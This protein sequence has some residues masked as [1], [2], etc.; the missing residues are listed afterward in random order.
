H[1]TVFVAPDVEHHSSIAE[2]IRVA[3]IL[4][5]VMRRAV[6]LL[7][8][9]RV[10]GSQGLFRVGIPLPEVAETLEGNYVHGR[11]ADETCFGYQ[12]GNLPREGQYSGCGVGA[13]ADRT[14]RRGGALR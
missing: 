4:T 7:P 9:D 8:H 11:S 3:E 10:P 5:D 1:E 14:G 13:R 12:Y 6:S 2:E